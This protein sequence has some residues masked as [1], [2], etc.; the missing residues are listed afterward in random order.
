VTIY[1]SVDV[2]KNIKQIMKACSIE[3]IMKVYAH[4]LVRFR[5][6]YFTEAREG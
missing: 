5:K 1:K 3:K 2:K 6:H 4:E